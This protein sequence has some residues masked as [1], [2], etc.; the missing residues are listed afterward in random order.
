M[1]EGVIARTKKSLDKIYIDKDDDFPE[2]QETSKRFY[3]VMDTIETFFPEDFM[4]I[5]FN[6]RPL[7]YC[8]FAVVYDQL[9]GLS[10]NLK[11]TKANKF[12]N[13]AAKAIM[14]SIEEILEQR[15]PDDVFEAVSRRTT[16]AIS[17]N[18]IISHLKKYI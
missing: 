15:A 8:L 7:F 9:Y 13:K 6:R 16:H 1:F 14:F 2:S 11:S 17:R 10:S 5:H 4:K 18:R 3:T 12:T